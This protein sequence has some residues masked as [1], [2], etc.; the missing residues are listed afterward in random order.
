MSAQGLPI[1]SIAMMIRDIIVEL[2][3]NSWSPRRH[4]SPTQDFV[5]YVT[6]E[7]AR[8]SEDFILKQ[9]NNDHNEIEGVCCSR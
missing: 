9:V 1:S 6:P 2:E 8:A 4:E 7:I 3:K 5:R